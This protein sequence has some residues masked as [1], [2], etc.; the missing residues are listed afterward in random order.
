MYCIER[1]EN[2]EIG[3]SLYTSKSATNTFKGLHVRGAYQLNDDGIIVTDLPMRLVVKT[4]WSPQW[5]ES[6]YFEHESID[7]SW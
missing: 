5:M 2:H 3:R 1:R 7:V 4:V 6:M